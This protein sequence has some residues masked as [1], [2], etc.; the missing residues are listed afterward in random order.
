MAHVPSNIILLLFLLVSFHVNVIAEE[1]EANIIKP[2]S[3]LYTGKQPSSWASPSGN[4]EFGFYRQ[5]EG[6]AAGIWLVG[7]PENTIVW[8]AKRDDPPVSSN[9][10]LEFTTQGVLLLRT[11]DGVGNVIANLSGVQLVDSASLL[12]TGNL[13]LY[14]NRSVVWESFDI[15]TDT[16]LGGQNLSLYSELISSVSSSN[17]STGHYHLLLKSGGL[18]ANLNISSGAAYEY[19][20]FPN[21]F[22]SP[23][24]NLNESGVLALYSSQNFD[25]ENVL[26]SGSTT[27][28]GTMII[29]RATLDHDGVFRLYSHQLES[30]TM[31]NKWQNLDDECE[32]PGRCGLNS[33][34]STSRGNDTECYCYPGF[35]F[36]DENAKFLGCSQNFTVDGCETK[37]DVVIHHN[38]TTLDNVSWAGNLYS[39]KRNLEKEDCKKACEDDCSCG[40]ALYSPNHCSMYSLPLKYGRKHVNITTTAFIKLIPGSTISPPPEKSQILISEGNQSLIL[41]MGLSLGSVA[42][43]CFVIAI[44]SFLLYRH[45]VQSY[46]KLLDSKSSGFA[47]QFTLRSFTFNEL[48]EATQGFQDEL[49]RGS[50]GAVYKGTLPGDGKSI[51]VKRLGMVKEGERDQFRTEMTAIG[52]NNHRNLVRLLGFCVEGSRKFLVYE[53][54]SN[55]SLAD[56]L[57]NRNERPVWKQRARIALDVAKGILYLHEECEVSII[58]CNIKPCNILLDDSLTA[59]ISDF[60]LAKLL[61][62][63]QRSSTSG[64]AWYSAPEW[65]NSAVLSVKVDVYSFGVILLEMICCRSNIEVEGR[66]AD[67]ILLSTFVYNCF[68]GGELNKLVEGEEEV[69]MKMVE[70]FVKVGLWCIQDDPNLRPLVKNVILM[71]EG[72]MNVPIPPSP[73]LPHV[74]N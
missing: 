31:S 27:G 40:G 14:E 57:F 19:W 68:V 22:S 29:Y 2:G 54:M 49:G 69:D 12:D 16:I 45:R 38:S 43:L 33:Y 71:L 21:G 13:V 51:A 41:T 34:C 10:T 23:V 62:P 44:C 48:D 39:V 58:H 30:N 42:S 53:Y 26:A 67:E 65:Q 64:A 73:S 50:F 11:E 47:E 17:H 66:S 72:T 6:Y 9:A 70:R 36:I 60:G 25:Q 7:R 20:V 74:T 37:R 4:F 59:K 52:R 46:E 61:R 18:V 1:D 55:G 24:L 8:T 5:G 32:V 3:S 56:F 35:I 28:N 15:P 63:N